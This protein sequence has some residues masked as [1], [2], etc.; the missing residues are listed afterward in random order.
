MEIEQF[1]DYIE[2]T[3]YP[4]GLKS[5]QQSKTADD[6]TLWKKTQCKRIHSKFVTGETLEDLLAQDG[7]PQEENKELLT[8]PQRVFIEAKRLHDD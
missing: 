1:I 4:S 6:I 8:L 5:L 3:V 2:Q 7:Y